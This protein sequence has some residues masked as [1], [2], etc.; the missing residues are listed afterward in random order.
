[1][2]RKCIICEDEANY[3]IKDSTD[4]YCEECAL[5]NFADLSYLQKVEEEALKLKEVKKSEL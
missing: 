4:H 5:Q 3:R 2:P 1:M